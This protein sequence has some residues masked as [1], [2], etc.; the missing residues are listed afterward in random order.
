MIEDQC[1]FVEWRNIN[2]KNCN[3]VQLVRDVFWD[4]NFVKALPSKDRKKIILTILIGILAITLTFL[5]DY[6]SRLFTSFQNRS[7]SQN[8]NC[9]F[10]FHMNIYFLFYTVL[11]WK[12]IT[13]ITIKFT[14]YLHN[15]YFK[16]DLDSTANGWHVFILWFAVALWSRALSFDYFQYREMHWNKWM[17]NSNSS[18]TMW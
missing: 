16:P 6:H 10:K 14:W 2:F 4:E 8:S 7:L 1:K 5:L 13:A 9:W 3:K 11:F 12:Y 15:S 18:T 17:R